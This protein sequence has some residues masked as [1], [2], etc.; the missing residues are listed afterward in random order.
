MLRCAFIFIGL[1]WA[2]AAHSADIG[3]W[4]QHKD[5]AALP[6][7]QCAELIAQ[8]AR[9][10]RTAD[11]AADSYYASGLCYLYSEKIARDPVAAGAWLARAAEQGH[12]LAKRALLALRDNAADDHAPGGHCHDLGLGRKLCHG[13]PT[14]S[15][16]Q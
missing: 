13:G 7:D 2:S 15:Q 10:P 3:G 12:P 5:R 4:M 14:P 8:A 1:G 16:S 11:G 9:T 6:V